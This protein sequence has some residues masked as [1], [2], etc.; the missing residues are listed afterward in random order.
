MSID[1]RIKDCHIGDEDCSSGCGSSP[2]EEEEEGEGATAISPHRRRGRVCPD[3]SPGELSVSV[4]TVYKYKEA[5]VT[6]TLPRVWCEMHGLHRSDVYRAL[7]D[8]KVYGFPY[9]G[10]EIRFRVG[11]KGAEV[12]EVQGKGEPGA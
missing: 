7:V 1:Q 5:T 8:M 3:Q 4:L 11:E 6:L 2:V 12:V 9:D 10:W